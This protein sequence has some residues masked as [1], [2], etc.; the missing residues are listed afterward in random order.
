M[1]NLNRT[2]Y[3]IVFLLL[4]AVSSR[5]QTE[6]V[7]LVN[8][9]MGNI[10]HLLVPTY[11]T[12]HLPNSMLR[13]YPNRKDYTSDVLNGLPVVIARHRAGTVFSLF[14]FQGD[15]SGLKPQMKY[16]YDHE[17]ITPYS[18]SVYLDDHG[19]DVDFGVSHQSAIYRFS[20]EKEGP[21]I[22]SLY[23][24]GGKLAWDGEILS[25]HEILKGSRKSGNGSKGDIKAFIALKPNRKPTQ[26]FS[27]TNSDVKGGTRAEGEQ[28]ALALQFS[29]EE[30]EVELSYGISFISE[31]Q[32]I[33]NLE[34]ELSGKGIEQLWGAGRDIWNEALG[35]IQVEG[36]QEA[37]RRVF[38]TSLYRCFER[39]VCIS[40]DGQYF[41]PFDLKVHRDNGRPFYTDDWIWDTYQA[42]HPL[43]VLIDPKKEEDILHSYLLMTDQMDNPWMPT[44]PSITGDARGMDSNHGVSNVIDAYRKGLRNFDLQKAYKVCKGAITEKTL[45]PWSD[46]PAG[47]LD[48]FYREHGYVPE[49]WPDEEETHP[50]VHKGERRQSVTITLGAAFDEWCLS[51]IAGELGKTDEHA[52]FLQHS[53]GYKK[54]YNHETGFFHPKDEDGRFIQPVDYES[55]GMPGARGYYGEN[56]AWVYSFDVKHDIPGLMDLMG[57]KAGFVERLDELFSTPLSERRKFVF[58]RNMPDHTGNVGQ[59]SMGNEP[60]FH[61]PY[62]YNFGDQPWKTQKRIRSL[63]DQ[64]FRNDLMGVPGDE[65]GGGM[66]A[67][68][69]YSLMGFYPIVPG[70]PE[71]TI[72]SP[73]F[74]NVKIKLENGKLLEIEPQNLTPENKYIQSATLNGKP[75]NIAWVKHSEIANGGKLIFKMGNKA[76]RE[77]GIR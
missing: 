47:K 57:G 31:E 22:L 50:E 29:G 13:I 30:K 73:A 12:V 75:L 54:L 27:V 3:F 11:P 32:A 59:F 34:R 60:S 69:V 26:L 53:K 66:S 2:L 70:N 7:D 38:Y 21:Q 42:H 41:S 25:G 71:Y 77:W 14:P 5:S 45:M 24:T 67:F 68:V 23:T 46:N 6:P 62:L 48:D 18:Y 56:N 15:V 65:D 20:F 33:K 8:P 36:G 17:K 44:F 55:P 58:F 74:D 64:W 35:K 76:N 1:Y 39:P 43:R 9:Y 37:D 19:I 52:Y 4:T 10:S 28:V 16:H 51:Q 40:E 72:G 49:R 63:L 61:I